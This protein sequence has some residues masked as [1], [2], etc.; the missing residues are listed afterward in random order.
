MAALHMDRRTCVAAASKRRDSGY[1]TFTPCSR[2]SD[3]FRPQRESADRAIER[4][5]QKLQKT[6]VA[7]FSYFELFN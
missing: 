7:R 5:I 6:L 1:G 4:S 2:S 3:G